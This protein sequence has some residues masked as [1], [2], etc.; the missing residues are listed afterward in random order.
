MALLLQD[1]AGRICH[2]RHRSSS[3]IKA[4]LPV[5]R[6]SVTSAYRVLRFGIIQHVADAKN[7]FDISALAPRLP[8]YSPAPDIWNSPTVTSETNH[9][10]EFRKRLLGW[11]G[12]FSDKLD[13]THEVGVRLVSFGQAV[14]FYLI[15]IG[16]WNPSLISFSGVMSD[17]SPVELIQHVSQISV[18]LMRLPR[19]DPSKPKRLMGFSGEEPRS[20]ESDDGK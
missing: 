7:P 18:L 16:F 14:V 11:I 20:A 3:E 5:G 13:E 10:S 8:G 9:A 15:D 4:I 2:S 6:H 1:R 12:D 17:G 19:E